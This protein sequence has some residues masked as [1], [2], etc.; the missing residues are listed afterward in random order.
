MRPARMIILA[1][2]FRFGERRSIVSPSD[3]TPD[4]ATRCA[5]LTT[6][7]IVILKEPKRLKDL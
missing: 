6:H 4:S 2:H 7:R 5:F 1:G 3:R